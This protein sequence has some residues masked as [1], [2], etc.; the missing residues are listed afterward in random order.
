ML[1]GARRIQIRKGGLAQVEVPDPK[2]MK[3]RLVSLL[4]PTST[5]PQIPGHDMDS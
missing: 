5:N 1:T 3:G 4:V 2:V